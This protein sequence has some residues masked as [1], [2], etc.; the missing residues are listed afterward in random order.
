MFSLYST[1]YLINKNRFPF[2]HHLKNFSE[3]VGQDGEVV[4]GTNEEGIQ[5][6]TLDVLR[7]YI[8]KNN[9]SNVYTNVSYQIKFSSNRF[10]GDLKDFALQNTKNPIK[11]QMDMDEIIPLSQKEK[12]V[13]YSNWLLNNDKVQALYVPSI[14]LYGSSTYI[15]KNHNIGQK[16]RIHKSGLKRGVVNFAELGNGLFDTSRSDSGELLSQSNKLVPTAQ[17][18]NPDFLKPENCHKLNDYIYTLHLGF[19]SLDYRESI[20][21]NW[22]NQKW[23]DRSQKQENVITDKQILEKEEVIEHNLRLD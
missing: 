16:W 9:L 23:Q 5:D 7:E 19:A 8:T 4:I 12:W 11:I 1:L 2:L 22:W 18:V 21:K 17:I 3:F 15:R 14:D 10:D 6:G 13:K 20:N